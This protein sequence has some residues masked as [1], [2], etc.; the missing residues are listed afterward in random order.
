MP[1]ERASQ[2]KQFKH[3]FRG[4]NSRRLPA[5]ADS[6]H[7]RADWFEIEKREKSRLDITLTWKIFR[8]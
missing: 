6:I 3:I 8:H 2:E 5:K 1:N 4:G 7:K